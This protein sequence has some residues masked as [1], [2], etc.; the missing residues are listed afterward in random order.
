[1]INNPTGGDLGLLM[2]GLGWPHAR[3]AEWPRE[4]QATVRA[5][6]EAALAVALTDGRAPRDVVELLGAVASLDHDVVPWLHRIDELTG[7][8]ADAGL[9]RLAGYWAVDLTWGEEPNWWWFPDDPNGP[10]RDW[11]RSPA[12]RD[13]VQA[14]ADRNPR[15]KNAAD[16]LIAIDSFGGDEGVWFYPGYGYDKM[17]FANMRELSRSL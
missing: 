7:P 3:F 9:V 2:R 1:V 11:F 5:T 6:L 17:A 12:V 14:F 8:A 4:Q 13:R 15:C 16:A 10:V